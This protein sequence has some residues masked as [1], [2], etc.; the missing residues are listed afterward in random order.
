VDYICYISRSKV[1]SLLSILEP[2][3]FGEVTEQVTNERS[4]STELK[5]GLSVAAIGN[6]FGGGIT[7]GRRDVIQRERKVKTAYV[8]KLND[9]LLAIAADHGD[10]PDLHDV[11]SGAAPPAIYVYFEGRFTADPLSRSPNVSEVVTLRSDVSGRPLLLDCSLRYFSES[12]TEGPFLLHSGN[13]GF[14]LS[15]RALHLSGVLVLMDADGDEVYGSPL[16]LK[17]DAAPMVAL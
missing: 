7:Y 8:H 5:T 4:R 11:I 16:Y 14:F 6:L 15:G 3:Q 9:V 2:E 13:S 17:L 12:S 10:I 1:D